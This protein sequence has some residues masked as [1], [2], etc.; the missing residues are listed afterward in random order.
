MLRSIIQKEMLEN[1]LSYK[2]SVI[3]ILS[4]IRRQDASSTYTDPARIA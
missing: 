3:S 1:L 4:A 2:S